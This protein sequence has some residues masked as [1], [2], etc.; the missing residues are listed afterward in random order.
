MLKQVL[1][2]FLLLTLLFVFHACEK[3]KTPSI[4]Q[5]PTDSTVQLELGPPVETRTPVTKY[6]SA[7]IGQTRIGGLNTKTPFA[8]EVIN[9]GLTE[10]WGIAALPNG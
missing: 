7:Y 9:S 2:S 5:N 8:F 6:S 3:P 10:P 4:N 1:R